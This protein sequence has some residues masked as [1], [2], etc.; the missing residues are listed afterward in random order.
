MKWPTLKKR[1]RY[2]RRPDGTRLKVA[3]S[4]A[5]IKAMKDG[6]TIPFCGERLPG[7]WWIEGEEGYFFEAL[8]GRVCFE[9]QKKR[10]VELT[11]ASPELVAKRVLRHAEEEACYRDRI[12]SIPF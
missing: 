2:R 5:A 8:G 3:G 6:E 11:P 4:A 9:G 10:V 7:V 12:D 1:Y